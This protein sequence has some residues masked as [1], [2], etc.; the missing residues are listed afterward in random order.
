MKALVFDDPPPCTNDPDL[1]FPYSSGMGALILESQAKSV[2]RK[3]PFR[4]ECLDFAL[5]RDD[6]GIWGGMTKKERRDIKKAARLGSLVTCTEQKSALRTRYDT[7]TE[8]QAL[9]D[10]GLTLHEAARELG[11]TY[12]NLRDQRAVVAKDI[13]AGLW[14]P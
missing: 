10:D 3:C 13:M 12:E 4:L 11:Q 6:A 9:L 2:C 5:R 8:S 1:F 7:Y 14:C